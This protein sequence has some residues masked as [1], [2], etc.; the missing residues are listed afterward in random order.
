MDHHNNEENVIHNIIRESTNDANHDTNSYM[1]L[2]SYDKIGAP[3]KT[4]ERRST[5]WLELVNVIIHTYVVVKWNLIAMW[6]STFLP[7]SHLVLDHK[8]KPSPMVP[9]EPPNLKDDLSS[10]N[11]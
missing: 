10:Q 2:D 4:M 11:L 9:L 8:S 7:D 3:T 5:I 1:N 6:I